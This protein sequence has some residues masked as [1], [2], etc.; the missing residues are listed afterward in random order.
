M[1]TTIKQAILIFGFGFVA[2]STGAAEADPFDLLK[3]DHLDNH[4]HEHEEEQIKAKRIR[5]STN[6]PHYACQ[7]QEYANQCRQY[8][9][10]EDAKAK[11]ADL[12]LGCESMPG[13]RF[14]EGH[15]AATDRLAR[16]KDI[17]RNNHDQKTL[18]YENHFYKTSESSNSTWDLDALKRICQDLEGTLIKG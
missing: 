2:L 9:V 14:T 16:C 1:M 11:L 10:P 15:C 5:L 3:D 7:L 18:V 6:A 17:V 8:A 4:E 12:K 13:G